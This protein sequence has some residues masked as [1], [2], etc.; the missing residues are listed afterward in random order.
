[1]SSANKESLFISSAVVTGACLALLLLYESYVLYSV[2]KKGVDKSF[3]STIALITF[4]MI[5]KFIGVIIYISK[6]HSE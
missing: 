4:A 2:G 3:L 5:I 1:M 6:D